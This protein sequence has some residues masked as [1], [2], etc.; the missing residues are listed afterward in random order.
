[1]PSASSQLAQFCCS[2]QYKDI[3]QEVVER[4]L[5]LFLD[6]YGSAVAGSNAPPV[7]A[8]EAFAREMGPIPTNVQNPNSSQLIGSRQYT[9][10]YFAAM[11]NG[12]ASHVVEQDDL[13][14]Q[15]VLHPAT[16][17]F[18]PLF[19]VAQAIGVTGQDFITAAV[20]GY[21]AGVR[22]GEFLGREHYRI[23][24]TTGTAGTLASAMAVS[25]ILNLNHQQTHHALGSA[26]TQAAGLWNS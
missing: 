11:V 3:P 25:S 15:S 12:A 13:H 24:H 19:A 8:L 16:V 9:S 1:M 7:K 5:D 14:N 20:V 26:G 2:L 22:V 10:P 17:V 4:T 6:W 23:F 21:E 18:P